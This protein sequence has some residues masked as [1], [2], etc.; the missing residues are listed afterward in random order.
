METKENKKVEAYFTPGTP[1]SVK[2][3]CIAALAKEEIDMQLIKEKLVKLAETSEP[4]Y[5]KCVELIPYDVSGRVDSGVSYSH[6]GHWQPND[7][8]M[9]DVRVLIHENC[10]K[11]DAVRMLVFTTDWVLNNFDDLT[12]VAQ[13]QRKDI[14]A[15]PVKREPFDISSNDLPF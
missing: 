1:Q 6:G 14:L 8:V 13:S 9:D 4:H 10:T 7:G 12:E 2:D 11:E 15:K 5:Y 3:I